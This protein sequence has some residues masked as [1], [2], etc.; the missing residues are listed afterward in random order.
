MALAL[1]QVGADDEIDLAGSTPAERRRAKD[2]L[3]MRRKRAQA[4]RNR[5][6]E[7]ITRLKPGRKPKEA[8]KESA[9]PSRGSSTVL[10]CWGLAMDGNESDQSD[11]EDEPLGKEGGAGAAR[12]K[13]KV[14][15]PRGRTRAE[16]V[17]AK[18]AKYWLDFELL[19]ECDLDSFLFGVSEGYA[20]SPYPTTRILGTNLLKSA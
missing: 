13:R 9:P 14:C 8:P 10:A 18:F 4:T 5:I 2:R 16:K 7:N 12:S 11:G 17:A 6:Q 19:E 1:L 3:D 20:V 15:G